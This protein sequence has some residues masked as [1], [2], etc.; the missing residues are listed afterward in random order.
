MFLRRFLPCLATLICLAGPL[1]PPAARAQS[2]YV[3]P[4]LPPIDYHPELICETG[5]WHIHA[6][7]LPGWHYS[8]EEYDIT[9][10]LWKQFPDGKGQYYGNGLPIKF[11][12][13]DGPMPPEGGFTG[14]PPVGSPTWQLRW[15]TF[16]LEMQKNGLSTA[17]RLRRD[18]TTYPASPAPIPADAWDA[19]LT[20]T[21][22]ALATGT[23]TFMFQG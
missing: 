14:P 18:E 7:T 16:R 11:F 21:L 2:E 13:T 19:I 6:P 1:V 10:G 20:D 17:F 3:V 5:K 9:D 15:I 4:S 22:P 8:L 12:V 23:R